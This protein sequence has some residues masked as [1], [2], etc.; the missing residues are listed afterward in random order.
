[1]R[2]RLDF[3]KQFIRFKKKILFKKKKFY[4]YLN[5]QKK[6]ELKLKKEDTI[7]EKNLF[8]TINQDEMTEIA[9]K[10]FQV[11]KSDDPEKN[12]LGLFI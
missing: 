9:S 4:L 6:K 12:L 2:Q 11:K 10:G 7:T 3:S 5:R 1:M 8:I